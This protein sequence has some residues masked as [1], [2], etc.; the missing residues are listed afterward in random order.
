MIGAWL[1]AA[2]GIGGIPEEWRTRLRAHD[3]IERDVERLITQ[4]EP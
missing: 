4:L 2:L 3:A 1:G